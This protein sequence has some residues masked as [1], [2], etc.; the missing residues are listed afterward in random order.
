[1]SPNRESAMETDSATAAGPRPVRAWP[2]VALAGVY[3]VFTLVV[4]QNDMAM[5]VRFMSG[6][7]SALAFLVIFLILWSSNGTLPGRTRLLGIGLLLGGAALGIALAH[8]SYEPVGFLMASVPYVLSAL[9]AWHLLARRWE[10]AK[11][12][13]VLAALILLGFGAFDLIRWNG[14]D[15]R[16]Q[17]SVSWRCRRRPSRPSSRRKARARSSRR[18]QRPGRSSPTTARNSAGRGA[19]ASCAVCASR[20]SGRTRRSP[21]RGRRSSA[22]AGPGSS[23]S[24]ATS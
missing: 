16:L 3:W 7:L 18:P 24:T 2:V 6:A 20:R 4:A 22:P 17:S 9:A 10:P 19:T 5:F 12:R 15:G 13:V 1:M 8:S 23:S 21:W 11:A 14:L